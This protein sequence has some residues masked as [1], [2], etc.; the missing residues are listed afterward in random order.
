MQT[1]TVDAGETGAVTAPALEV[2]GFQPPA[3]HALVTF[4]IDDTANQTY[5]E[6]DG[7]A[8]K[9]SF[10]FDPA[11][12]V[13]T[14]NGSW[15]GPYP[16]LH[17]DGPWTD[18]GHEPADAVAGDHVWS[19]AIWVDN[20]AAVTLEYGAIRGSVDGSD[21]A[22]IW[23]GPNGSVNIPQGAAGP[24]AA[25]GLVL[26]ELGTVDLRLTIDLSADGANLAPAFQGAD[27]ADDATVK[28][29]AW[30]WSE[31]A[32]VD[33]GTA[34]DVTADDG[35]FTFLLSEHAGPHDGLLDGGDQPEFVFVLGGVEYKVGGGC[36]TEGVAA[37]LDDG[38]GWDNTDVQV[39][40]NGNT[41]VAVP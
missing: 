41:Y 24:I 27:Y 37:Y 33:D 36:A 22:W 18:G 17:D 11:T 20:S 6:A 15:G 13:L 29:S 3:D 14:Y 32:L 31:V 38:S 23:V 16:M 5:A 39:G 25:T 26:P 10:S 7:L 34:G 4:A 21:G 8:W 9:G 40:G 30:G 2:G 35:I 19:V 28:G 1:V 12:R